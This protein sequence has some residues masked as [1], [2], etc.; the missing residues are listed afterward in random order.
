MNAEAHKKGRKKEKAI[1][2]IKLFFH[3]TPTY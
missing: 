2:E 1:Y 3:A